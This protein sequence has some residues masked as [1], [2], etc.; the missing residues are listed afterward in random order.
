MTDKERRALTA[1]NNM[2]VFISVCLLGFTLTQVLALYVALAE[3]GYGNVIVWQVLSWLSLGVG[4]YYLNR[5][6]EREHS[7][8]Y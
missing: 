6:D 1:R 8:K 5:E 3:R 4:L 7:T 2:R